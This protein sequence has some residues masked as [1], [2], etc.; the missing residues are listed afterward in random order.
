MVKM[1]FSEIYVEK[2]RALVNNGNVKH[3]IFSEGT[4]QVEV[5]D[6]DLKQSFWPFLQ[7]DDS[8]EVTDC[9]CVCKEAEKIGS[10]PHLAAA[11]LEIYQGYLTPLHVRF[12]F[13][14]WNLL[15]QI[16]AKRH[17]YE[18]KCL[19]K[20]K[21]EPGY[22][23]QSLTKKRLFTIKVL[24]KKAEK[25]LDEIINHRVLETEETSLKF[26]NLSSEEISLWKEGKPTHHLQYELSFWSDLAKWMMTLQE[27]GQ[28][29]QIK[30]RPAKGV[31]P[32][33]IDIIF[34][35]I[36]AS[37]YIAEVNW[38][39]IIPALARVDF[40]VP[41]YEHQDLVFDSI[42]YD[43]EEKIFRIHSHHLEGV[44]QNFFKEEEDA[45][46]V[47][48]G[49]W[50]FH[51]EV[52]FYP[53]EVDPLLRYETIPTELVG[54][55]LMKYPR[56]LE[57]Y[58]TNTKLYLGICPVSYN[59]FFD[60]QDR[61]HICAYLFEKGDLQ[62]SCSTQFGSWVFLQNQGFYQLGSLLFSEIEKIIPK[63]SLGEFVSKNKMWLNQ[64]EGFQT[65]LTNIE[66]YLTFGVD[67]WDRLFFKS[68]AGSFEEVTGVLDLQ[69]W[70]YIEGRGFYA[71]TS[72]KIQQ[73]L[74][75][76]LVIL[77]EDVS[78]FIK[79]H[80]EDLELIKGFFS[81]KQPVEKSGLEIFVDEESRIV[82]RPKISFAKGYAAERV[83][84]FGDYSYIEKEGFSLL[85]K[86]GRIPDSYTR[87]TILE[88]DEEE[89]F[90]VDELPMLKPFILYMDPCL[91][92]PKQLVLKI[93]EL[94]EEGE[95]KNQWHMNLVYAS[96]YG[97]VL[98]KD[99]WEA[100]KQKRLFVKTTAGLIF[101]EDS[102][103]SWLREISKG[104]FTPDNGINLSSLEWIRLSLLETVEPPTTEE[105]RRFLEEMSLL[106]TSDTF[107]LEGLKSNLRPYQEMGVRWL[108]FLYSYGLSGLLCDEMG[109]GKT[110]QA[111]ALL[112]ACMN[113]ENKKAKKFLVV[114]PTSVIYHWEE[115]LKR[116]L[117]QA[118][119]L[120]FYGIQ[121]S[122]KGFCDDVEI[123]LTSYGTL[124]SEKDPL[125]EIA[126][127]VAVFDE[128]HVAKNAYS[129]THKALR[130]IQARMK[131]GLTGTPIENRLLELH[132]LFDVIL[133]HYLPSES[134]YKELFVI[135]VERNQ[136]QEK[137][138]LLTKLIQ[139]FILRRKKE[140]V[141]QDLPEKTEE[142]AYVDLSD[143]QRIMYKEICE[144]NK[145]Q[146]F[147]E[148][149]QEK[150]SLP[151][152]HIFA[153]FSLLKQVCNHPALVNKDIENYE[154]YRSGKWELFV[155]LLHEARESG[156]KLVVFSQY[157]KML[158]IIELYLKKNQIGYAQIRGS[159]KNRREEMIRFREDPSCEVFIG[160]LQAAG[161]GIDLVSA[162]VVIHYDRWWNPA[163][164]NQATDRVHRIGQNRGVQVF[165]LV[166][167]DTIEE[168]I[169]HIIEKK[170][171]LLHD[172]VS[173]DDQD[174]V[175]HLDRAELINLLKKIDTYF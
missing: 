152:M 144:K 96:E 151:Y 136:D 173:Y 158:D 63:H 55:M 123:L 141:L 44:E 28:K 58:L 70:V 11:L 39:E 169:H 163:K 118:K 3:V 16:A 122:L 159:T 101:L 97:E 160:S 38:E 165:K 133:P 2:G 170:L 111:M 105:G 76:G 67:T 99:L 26:S 12:R 79:S 143:E 172:I 150:A 19:K 7:L 157:L 82:V 33:E 69:E 46:R 40:P 119:V 98:L 65:H 166:S 108:W 53:K 74:T 116:F 75:P 129:Q 127:E 73:V 34:K 134:M 18:T 42:L 1:P 22:Y 131:L 161:V 57:K 87:E 84:F 17:G 117:P 128:L 115:L 114:C 124:R 27:N 6:S 125:S 78:S 14:L 109:L 155:E 104:H 103:F 37:F 167:K 139:P 35:D 94:K 126:F 135:P 23:A 66:C 171:T 45:E 100:I 120:V 64:Y 162:S 146:I 5:L 10:C 137:K 52:G 102:R 145:E 4:Y 86:G 106:Q 59:L 71:K 61:F 43:E 48:L 72:S 21:G 29:Y 147:K 121:R 24:N 49:E 138:K 81:L 54:K 50:M 112:A 90:I 89:A 51:P 164:E 31:L 83:R 25:Q 68:T 47:P 93:N 36:S 20:I 140:Q 148:L 77:K 175:K 15:M 95:E 153:L 92:V 154:Q 156:Q 91:K 32:K 8:G 132:S 110:H 168:H 56:L 149:D 88:A 174:Q 62:K 142:I 13:S 30:V 107:T 60:K 85:P 113:V 80:E 41:I 130:G 9:F